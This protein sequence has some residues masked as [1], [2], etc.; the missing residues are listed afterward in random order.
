ML[1][2]AIAKAA[3]APSE[4]TI[5]IPVEITAEGGRP[6]TPETYV[7]RLTSVTENAPMPDGASGGTAD[8][9]IQGPGEGAFSFTYNRTG[10]YLYKI[11]Q[12][13]GASTIC[14]YDT[15]VYDLYVY[16]TRNAENGLEINAFMKKGT[17][18]EKPDKAAFHNLYG[19]SAEYTVSVRKVVDVKSGTAPEDSVFTFRMTPEDAS[20]PMPGN[21]SGLMPENASDPMSGNADVSS[22]LSTGALTMSVTGAGEYAFGKLQFDGSH[23]GN[24]YVYTV[25][26]IDKGEAGYTYDPNVYKLTIKVDAA[27]EGMRLD[28]FITDESGERSEMVFTNTYEKGKT[29]D[30]PGKPGKSTRTG[31]DSNVL[32]WAALAAIS[33]GAIGVLMFLRRKDRQQ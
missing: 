20:Y 2:S 25:E 12:V 3:E 1:P 8:L 18:E 33:L 19:G 14:E 9:S 17:E 26:E 13:T 10:V 5:D 24:T 4:Q 28:V 23:C 30:Q 16:I 6:S 21:A 29:P 32:M 11:F 15:T 27:E 22:D 31:D 7:V